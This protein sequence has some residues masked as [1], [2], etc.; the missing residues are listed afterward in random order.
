MA[1]ALPLLAAPVLTRLYTP[2]AFGLQTL[3][4]GLAASLAVL[5][6]CRMDLALVLPPDDGEALALVAF[7][8]ATTLATCALTWLAVPAAAAVT[9]RELPLAWMALLPLMV[10]ATAVFQLA[11]G[12]AARRRAFRQVAGAGVANQGTYVGAA[13]ALGLAGTWS[14]GLVIAKLAGQAVGAVLVW[15][16]AAAEISAAFRRRSLAAAMAAARKYRQFLVF[17]TPYSL[18]GSV[19]RDAPVYAF[20]AFAAVGLAGFFGLSRTVLLAPTLLASNAFSQVFYREAVALKGSPRLQ[21]LTVTLL[22]AGLLVLAPLFAF[23]AVWGD[24]LFATLFG[25]GWRTAGVF[26]MVLAPAA[27]LAVQ[28]GWPERLFEVNMRQGVSF[29]VQLTSDAVTAL[30]FAA[31]F[32]FTRDG[33]VAVA[34]YAACNVLYHH[35]YL[36]AIFRISGFSAGLLA[37]TLLAGWL[38]FGASCAA[39]AVIRV[40]GGQAGVAGWAPAMALAAVASAAL[41]WRL[42]RHGLRGSF[43]GGLR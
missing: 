23:C 41:G 1:Q 4:M 27:W 31:T 24:A 29:A 28:T 36:A 18:V 21:D 19:A 8:A 11:T 35:V 3:F 17:N 13:L 15:R 2:E 12:L 16:T 9:G 40:E 25:E 20:S 39:L 43:A 42:A 32:W 22:R 5:A 37:R 38:V 33:V 34:V 26:A 10:L 6:T 14:L 30:A 7:M